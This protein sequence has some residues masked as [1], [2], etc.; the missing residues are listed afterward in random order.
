MSRYLEQVDHALPDRVEGFYLV[1]SAA[2]QAFQPGRS[3]IDFVAVTTGRLDESELH[4]LRRAQRNLYRDELVRTVTRVPWRWPLVCSLDDLADRAGGPG[5]TPFT[6]PPGMRV[7]GGSM[8]AS[9][10]RTEPARAS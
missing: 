1:G 2:L 7:R 6:G 9:R 10:P 4:R 8:A 5:G 3:D